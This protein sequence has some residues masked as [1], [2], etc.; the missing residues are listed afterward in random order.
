MK[1]GALYCFACMGSLL[2]ASPVAIGQFDFGPNATTLDFLGMV[3]GAPVND[4]Y[5]D[6]GVTFGPGFYMSEFPGQITNQLGLLP[7]LP[8]EIDFSRPLMKVGFEVRG[9]DGD[10]LTLTVLNFL[11]NPAGSLDYQIDSTFQFVGISNPGKGPCYRRPEFW[12]RPNLLP[13]N[14]NRTRPRARNEMD[15]WI[16]GRDLIRGAEEKETNMTSRQKRTLTAATFGLAVALLALPLK[17]ASP[18]TLSMVGKG[19]CETGQDGTGV[20]VL[21][22]SL[23]GDWSDGTSPHLTIGGVKIVKAVD[24]C[25]LTLFHMFT[26]GEIT[27]TARVRVYSGPM[28]GNTIERLRVTLTDVLVSSYNLAPG[29]E[30]ITLTFSKIEMLLV[31][32]GA[33][34]CFDLTTNGPC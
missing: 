29:Q 26:T 7:E 15:V 12:R 11:G 31:D 3:P 1:F 30:G 19:A 32:S 34:T 25:T 14:A 16:R 9:S 21:N 27:R 18:V 24:E 17:A 20:S 5:A 8:L 6:L 22:F 2:C 10:V 28:G 4:F 13:E 33:K 23:T